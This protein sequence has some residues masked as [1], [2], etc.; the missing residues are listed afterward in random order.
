MTRIEEHL[1]KRVDASSIE[2]ISKVDEW[3]EGSEQR[4]R[5]VLPTRN[6]EITKE[7][8]RKQYQD[9][10]QTGQLKE[11]IKAEQQ[12]RQALAKKISLLFD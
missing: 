2:E 6:G 10:I 7:A 12:G 8:L 3:I 1:D 11:L 9:K 5:F 4:E